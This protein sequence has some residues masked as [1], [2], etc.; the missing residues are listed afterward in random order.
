M[1]YV[2]YIPR[3]SYGADTYK[4]VICGGDDGEKPG[5]V[6]R[7][8]QNDNEINRISVRLALHCRR[9]ESSFFL[10]FDL[11]FDFNH[12]GPL[13]IARPVLTNV[14]TCSHPS[15]CLSFAGRRRHLLRQFS[16]FLK[17]M[18]PPLQNCIPNILTTRLL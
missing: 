11:I 16:T 6:S 1:S 3:F 10:I 15:S 5:R 4:R 13:A 9:A 7:L 18:T 8:H 14:C 12:L 17:T 2:R